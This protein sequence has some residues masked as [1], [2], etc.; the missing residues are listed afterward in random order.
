MIV[1]DRGT[2]RNRTRR[3]GEEVPAE[4]ALEDGHLVVELRGSKLRGGFALTRTGTD[5]RRRERWLLVKK[6][7]AEAVAARPAGAQPAGVGA[8]R[9][10]DR[11]AGGGGRMAQYAPMKAVLGPRAVLGPERGCSSASSTACAREWWSSR[12]AVRLVSR[13]GQIMNP[14]YPE[15]VE[16]IEAQDLGD[17]VADGEIV[18]F[19]RGRTSFA[20]LQRRMQIHD[21]SGRAAAASP[22]TSTSSTCSSSTART[23]G[24]RPCASASAGCVERFGSTTGCAGRLTAFGD[25]EAAYR[26]ACAH[27][28]EGV[29]AK[30]ADSPYVPVRSRDWRK[31][32]CARGQELV[33]GGWTAGRGARRRLGALLLGYWD[34]DRLRYA[35]KV[36]TG[37]DARSSTGW[38]TSWSGGSGRRRRSPT[39]DFPVAPAGPSPELVAQIAFTEWTRDG[40]LR[41]PRYLGLRDDKPAREV[42]RELPTG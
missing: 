10:H 14:T 33:I 30:R 2:Y 21:P 7:D 40:R 17:L 6:R 12:G 1:W 34:G 9:P 5:G 19:E 32:K 41:H 13:S 16:T 31:I 26:H 27:G 39:R 37:F 20:R 18:A 4:R 3:E 8:Q 11:A 15:L 42:V 36:G 25:G 35:G 22:S 23:C 28:W 24:P 29:I 38:R